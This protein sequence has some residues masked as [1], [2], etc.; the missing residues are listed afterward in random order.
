MKEKKFNY[1]PTIMRNAKSQFLQL[2]GLDLF[3]KIFKRVKCS[4]YNL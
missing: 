3:K 4:I 1:Q 2:N